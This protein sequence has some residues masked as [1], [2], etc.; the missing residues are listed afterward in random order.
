LAL[1]ANG[2]SVLLGTVCGNSEGVFKGA[3]V[4]CFTSNASILSS[5]G[6]VGTSNARQL[7]E[8]SERTVIADI[9]I[10]DY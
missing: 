1:V 4:S 6:L 9:A 8:R 7:L 10:W 2:T 5:C 3:V